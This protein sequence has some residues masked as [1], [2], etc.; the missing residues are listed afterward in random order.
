MDF[1]VPI[2]SSPCPDYE[3]EAIFSFFFI[4]FVS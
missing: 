4:F 2:D 1:L 3:F